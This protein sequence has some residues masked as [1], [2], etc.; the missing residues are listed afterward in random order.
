M[1]W[2]FSSKHFLL[3]LTLPYHSTLLPNCFEGVFRCQVPTVTFVIHANSLCL[4]TPSSWWSPPCLLSSIADSPF[5]PPGFELTL[6]SVL[7]ALPYFLQEVSSFSLLK[8]QALLLTFL[9]FISP[10]PPPSLPYYS[11]FDQSIIW[12]FLLQLFSSLRSLSR[13]RPS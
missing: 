10:S 7:M 4:E 13:R 1:L 12:I 3:S 5:L 11:N 6:P 2:I 8:S 9:A